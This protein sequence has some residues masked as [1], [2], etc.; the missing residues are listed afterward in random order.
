[1]DAQFLQ[2]VWPQELDNV[3]LLIVFC[4]HH[5]TIYTHDWNLFTPRAGAQAS[6]EGGQEWTGRD[7]ILKL[8]NGHFTILRHQDPDNRHPI[9]ELLDKM[10]DA[11]V[12][13]NLV[14]VFPLPFHFRFISVSFP[15]HFR[16]ISVSFPFH[17]T[18]FISPASASCCTSRAFSAVNRT[19]RA[20]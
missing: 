3:R 5:G 9:Q 18:F 20:A 17:F 6:I 14:R 11:D 2:A 13:L 19:Q 7:V 10:L 16:F 15:F 12:D 4:D 1:M 8:Q